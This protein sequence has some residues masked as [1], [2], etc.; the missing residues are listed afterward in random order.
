M[1]TSDARME[2]AIAGAVKAGNLKATTDAEAYESADVAIVDIGL[3]V[4]RTDD[5]PTVDFT[6]L[7]AAVRSLAERLPSGALMIVET[8][9]PPGTCATVVAPEIEDA[10]RERGLPPGSLLLAHAY[11]RVMPGPE[12]LDSIVNYWRVYAGHTPEAADACEAFL[13]AVSSMWRSTR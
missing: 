4:T 1:T 7:R 11:E 12:Y 6:A 5:G 13:S 9:V 2:E 3:D 8:T 10:L